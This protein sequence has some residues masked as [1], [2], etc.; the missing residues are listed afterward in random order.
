MKP[1]KTVLVVD[2]DRGFREPLAQALRNANYR[3]LEAC[4]GPGAIAMLEAHHA[5]IDV[6][7][8]DLVL[9]GMDGFQVI[10]TISRRPTHIKVIAATSVLRDHFLE[11]C[12]YLGADAVL[13]KPQPGEPFPAEEWLSAIG[14]FVA[15]E[16]ERD[17][18]AGP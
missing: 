6:A 16:P 18:A 3:V 1:P 7:V 2:D 11:M 10:G 4:D 17:P 5:G 15:D 8:I 9:P 12:K 13:R 14:S